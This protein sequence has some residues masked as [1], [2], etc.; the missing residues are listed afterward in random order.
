MSDTTDPQEATRSGLSSRALLGI[1]A[2]CAA[3]GVRHIGETEDIEAKEAAYDEWMEGKW[4]A[5]RAVELKR[6]DMMRDAAGDAIKID[7]TYLAGGDMVFV[8]SGSLSM[9]IPQNGVV[10]V[11]PN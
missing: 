10:L 6:G 5:I 1:A 8:Q 3:A 7:G 9:H 2:M 11:L 4:K